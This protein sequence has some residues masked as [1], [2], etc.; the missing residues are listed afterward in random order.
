LRVI[1]P[2]GST[3]AG[4]AQVIRVGMVPKLNAK[5]RTTDLAGGSPAVVAAAIDR[6]QTAAAGK[7]SAAVVVVSQSDP[8]FAMPAAAWAA[9]SGD[10]ILFVNRDSVPPATTQAI[11]AHEG[12][13]VYVLGPSSTVSAGVLRDLRRLGGPVKRISG[14]D[15]IANAIAFARYL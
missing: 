10:P 1:A 3:A 4:G 5:T 12:A 7:P 6:F 9:R 2:G 14:E 8:A 15:P 11:R 13:R